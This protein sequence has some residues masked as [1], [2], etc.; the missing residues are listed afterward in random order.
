MTSLQVKTLDY[1][2]D[3]KLYQNKD[4]YRV[5]VDALLLYDFVNMP[6]IKKLADLGAGSGVIGMLL[7]KKYPNAFVTLI[8]IQESL[9]NLA[10]QNIDLNNLQDRVELIE[11]DM[12]EVSKNQ[13]FVGIYDA[14]LSNPP[15]RQIKTGL[16]SPKNEKAIA[17]HETNLSL[18]QLLKS[19]SNLLRHHGHFFMIYLPE[20]LS[21]VLIKMKENS[22]EIKCMRFVHSFINSPAKMILIE[23]VKGA[24]SGLNVMKPL[25]I[26]S[27][28][29]NYSDEVL[30]IY[31]C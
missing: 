10:R 12:R 30:S 14:V 6:R 20:R 22:L 27:E 15:F 3:I 21:E 8:E 24:K 19:A 5:S 23:A 29:D 26:Y 9:A 28:K 11:G 25:V 17:R 2:R 31:K 7:A 18:S 4:G 1:L 16:I 13:S